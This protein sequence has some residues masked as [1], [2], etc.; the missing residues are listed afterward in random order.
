VEHNNLS[1]SLANSSG[2]KN[3]LTP[4][5]MSLFYP[6]AFMVVGVSNG[7]TNDLIH[8]LALSKVNAARYTILLIC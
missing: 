8:K 1:T 5:S 7:V 2:F 6:R 3:K 4:F